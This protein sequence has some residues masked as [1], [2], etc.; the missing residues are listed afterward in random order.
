MVTTRNILDFLQS[1]A[2]HYI[3]PSK[4]KKKPSILRKYILPAKAKQSYYYCVTMCETQNK[5][6]NKTYFHFVHTSTFS[7]KDEEW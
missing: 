6:L 7:V 3:E 4:I 5:L 2:L 1:N